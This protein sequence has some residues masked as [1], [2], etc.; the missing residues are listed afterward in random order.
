M[1]TYHQALRYV[2]GL[3]WSVIPVKNKV[4][5]LK[6]WIEF[7]KRRPT[8]NELKEWFQNTDNGIGI[9]TG[10]LSGLTVMDVDTKEALSV[11]VSS[12]ISAQTRRGQ[13]F[14]FKYQEGVPN[15]VKVLENIDI[16]NEGGYVCAP[17]TPGYHWINAFFALSQLPSFP[18]GILPSVSVQKANAPGWIG[19]A[20]N[21]MRIGNIDDSLTSILG[22]LRR[23]GWA[24]NDALILLEP[25]AS[26][27]G[28]TPG[29]LES[30]IAHIWRAYSSAAQPDSADSIDTFL[31]DMA[32][33]EWIVPG[34]IAKGTMGFVAGLPET[35]KTWLL[36]DLAIECARD[37]GKWLGK[38]DVQG[39]RVL[40]IDQERFKGETQRRLKSLLNAKQLDRRLLRESLFVRCG[41]TTRLDLDESFRAFKA[42]LSRIKPDMVLIDSFATAHTKEENDRKEIQ[43]VLERI[44]ELRTE[45]NCTFIF[46][47][48]EG[49][50]VYTDKENKEAPNAFRMVGSVGKAAAA[51]F[52][53]TV[54]RYD[55]QTCMVFNTKNSLAP[56]VLSFPVSVTDTPK[57][58]I[59]SSQND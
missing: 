52:V 14:Y 43:M 24:E 30:K 54:R 20:L 2:V 25:H 13:H 12:P 56:G 38:Y 55:P 50:S 18:I 28:A 45:F 39:A 19:E 48:H 9:V 10:K 33:I 42:E 35:Y 47:D 11:L 34:M 27:K 6:S 29:H 1:T 49:K 57:G 41:S 21:G 3:K 36:L 22:R 51:E 59:V 7:Q 53:F 4:P 32:P 31:E 15:H 26:A 17:P 58:I 23:D 44:K 16:R 46:I 8:E 37:G 5:Q 40:F